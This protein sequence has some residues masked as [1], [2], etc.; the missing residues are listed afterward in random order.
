[1]LLTLLGALMVAIGLFGYGSVLNDLMDVQHDRAFSPGR[2]IPHGDI[3]VPQAVVG[4]LGLFIIAILGAMMLGR[5]SVY[6]TLVVAAALLF[7]NGTGRFIPAVGV[8]TVG[9]VYAVHMLIPDYQTPLLIA[10]WLSMSH[11]MILA[12]LVH[13]LEDKRPRLTGRGVG[14]IVC[15]WAF[16]SAVIL[17][18]RPFR[19]D[20]LWPADLPPLAI[21]WP[22]AAMGSMAIVGWWKIRTA[23]SGGVASERLKRYG[24]AWH[25]AYAAAWCAA[26]GLWIPAMGFVVLGL[27]GFVVMTVL[28]ELARVGPGPLAYR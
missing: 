17:L 14:G 4:L 11:V 19:G 13:L 7:Y 25:A 9:L 18:A 5:D 23:P 27:I 24:A 10:V 2:P 1:L 20:E 22:C 6:L 15:G 16:W 26:L 12:V 28:K 21:L 3:R 8:V